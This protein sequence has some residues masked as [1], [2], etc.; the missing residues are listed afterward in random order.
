MFGKPKSPLRDHIV[1]I[2]P[3]TL[4][5]TIREARSHALPQVI[6]YISMMCAGHF[7]TTTTQS[8]PQQIAK[9]IHPDVLAF[10][11]LAFSIYA[12]REAFS[13][14]A[15]EIQRDMEDEDDGVEDQERSAMGN[16][17]KTAASAC[18]HVVGRITSWE[19]D[20]ILRNRLMT[21]FG[22]PTIV[23][24][25]GAAERFRFLLMCIGK[26]SRPAATYGR[27]SLDLEVT[28]KAMAVIQAFASTIPEGYAQTL[29]LCMDEFDLLNANRTA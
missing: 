21:Y 12:V 20:D 28:L 29:R 10:E 15:A 4:G 23:G 11:A 9:K 13:P 16:A 27:V 24:K 8:L 2:K 6:A 25:E 14:M 26:E 19:T 22:A 7:L 18:S 1:A 3:E 17:F 5:P